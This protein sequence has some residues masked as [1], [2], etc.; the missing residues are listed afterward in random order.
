MWI[1]FY[2]YFILTTIAIAPKLVLDSFWIPKEMVFV[3]G[4]IIFIS[5]SLIFKCNKKTEYKNVWLAILLMY[6][7]IGFVWLFWRPLILNYLN[8][9]NKP[10][11]NFW[12]F[13]PFMNLLVGTFVLR[14][15]V[16]YTD[17][18]GRW[19]QISKLFV[20]SG[21]VISVYA[22]LQYFGIEHKY[23]GDVLIWNY[24]NGVADRSIHM[25]TVFFNEFLTGNFV[26]MVSP[27]CLLFK[28]GRYKIIYFVMFVCVILTHS[29][30]SIAAFIAGFTT[31]LF[32]T[33]RMKLSVLL[34][35]LCVSG[36]I[37]CMYQH[38][39]S[40]WNNFI[41][42]SGRIPLWKDAIRLWMESPY[43]G[44]GLG[45][46]ALF[47]MYKPVALSAHNE[48]IQCLFDLG[49]LGFIPIVG[50]MVNVFM[51]ILSSERSMLLICYISGFFSF[52][53]VSL[54]GFPLRIAPLA[55]V[56]ICYVAGLSVLSNKRRV[57][58]S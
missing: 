44:H 28:Q 45:K 51:D 24:S 26:A 27:M 23:W 4:G 49:L 10:L 40:Y 56:G 13:R 16:E 7:S 9:D 36:G 20:W 5:S 3:A 52:L 47:Q 17:S 11:W 55:L 14:T 35:V 48:F 43:I 54:G 50:F 6:C 39:G 57:L 25:I 15:L 21:L 32:L 18:L 42:S 19:I 12:N 37:F 34:L 53:V 31:Y 2:I 58:W 30:L 41:S 8:P 33:G 46:F 1:L 38:P 22:I 29:V